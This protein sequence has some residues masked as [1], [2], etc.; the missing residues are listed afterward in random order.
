MPRPKKAP[1]KGAKMAALARPP[2]TFKL[3]REM[4]AQVDAIARAEERPRT[5]IIEIA[6]RQYVQNH[7]RR[8]VA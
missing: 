5:K 8:G 4:L 1:A 2:V 7:Q 3:D 6:V